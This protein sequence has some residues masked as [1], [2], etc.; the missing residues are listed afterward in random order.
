MSA[1]KSFDDLWVDLIFNLKPG[2]QIPNWTAYSGRLGDY[3]TVV[4]ASQSAIRVDSPGARN[5]QNV[6][7]K[8]FE[9]IWGIWADYKA[10][11][12]RRSD[13]TG[14]TRFSKYIISILHWYEGEASPTWTEGEGAE[15]AQLGLWE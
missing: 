5:L 2:Q 12:L 11:R 1:A 10:Q 14:L 9:M 7:K 3:M 15:G 4:S 8:D 13:I 6:P